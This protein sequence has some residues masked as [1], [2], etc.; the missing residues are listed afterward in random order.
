M[1]RTLYLCQAIVWL[2]F[3]SSAVDSRGQENAVPRLVH[4][5]G[6]LKSVATQPVTGAQGV[7][8]ALYR[9]QEGGSPLW[10]ETQNI[11]IDEQGRFAALLGAGTNGGLPLDV[12][13]SGESR[14]LGVQLSSPG[15]PE[16]A[17]VLLVS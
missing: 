10:V 9:D 13:A 12:F 7:T 6:V 1:R 2:G 16:Q 15:E 14:W 17:R 5:N 3:L 4:F 11:R 8:F